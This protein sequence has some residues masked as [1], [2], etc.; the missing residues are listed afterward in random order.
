METFANELVWRRAYA[1]PTKASPTAIWKLWSDV[2]GWGAWNAGIER[3]QLHGPFREGTEFTMKP[4]GQEA[5]RS[6]LVRV[7]PEREF[8]DETIV[9]D[10]TVRV[11]HRIERAT[12]GAVTI[13]YAVEACGPQSAEIGP[14]ISADFPEV[15]EALT[16][17]AE[18][19]G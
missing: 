10:L 11:S 14:M 12:D 2:E 16:R 15:L 1:R 13:V 17:L 3:I 7:A 5:I 6:R 9:G 19:R 4:P 8:V 18:S